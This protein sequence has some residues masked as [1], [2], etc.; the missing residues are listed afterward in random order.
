MRS[1][2][3]ESTPEQIEEAILGGPYVHPCR[4]LDAAALCPD[5]GGPD[6]DWAK[7]VP[8]HV[9]VQ[10]LHQ[11]HEH[12]HQLLVDERAQHRET[13]AELDSIVAALR[14]VYKAATS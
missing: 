2:R 3:I 4:Y 8:V 11:Q 7:R 14:T 6:R 13:K 10:V 12:T 1:K 9:V 5:L